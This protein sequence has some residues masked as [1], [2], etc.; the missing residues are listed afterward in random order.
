[1]TVNNKEN[2]HTLYQRCFSLIVTKNVLLI[3]HEYALCGFTKLP[4]VDLIVLKDNEY[5]G[6][7]LYLSVSMDMVMK[8]NAT[9]TL[10]VHYN[11]QFQD[12]PGHLI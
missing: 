1:M 3:C 10:S 4:F 8:G 2:G 5:E 9:E 6:M 11:L 12:P 7:L